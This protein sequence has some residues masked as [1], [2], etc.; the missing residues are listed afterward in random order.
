MAMLKGFSELTVS[1]YMASIL[2]TLFSLPSF[3][4]RYSADQA[5]AHPQ[6][7][8]KLL[9]AE[10]LECQML[11]ISDGLVSGR[12][13]HVA[14]APPVAYGDMD[15]S[16]AEAPKFQE[17]VRPSQFKALIGKGHEEFATMRQQDSEEFLQHLLDR[18]R[19]EAKR[20]G[21][22]AGSEPTETLR[23]AMEQRLQ[24]GLCKRVGYKDEVVDLASLPV[25]AVD[26]GKGQDDKQ[27]WEK[28]DLG[29]CIDRLCADE[30]LEGYACGH[31]QQKTTA[32]K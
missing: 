7:C 18:L 19:A 21:R 1:C 15:Q 11:K 26:L 20:Q 8:E 24:C 27:I 6:T 2:Q 13:S 10:C 3:R 30:D 22:T 31:C 12:Y 28:Q 14:R 32:V 16:P 23:F 29:D 17:G 9:P 4:A 25:A 5:T